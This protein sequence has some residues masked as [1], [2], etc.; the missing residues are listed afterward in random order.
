MYDASIYFG[1]KAPGQLLEERGLESKGYVLATIHRAENT[2][3]PENLRCLFNALNA[4]ANQMPVVLPLHPRTRTALKREN[5]LDSMSRGLHLLDPVGYLDMVT[6]EKNASLIATDSGGVQKEAFFHRVPCVTLRHETEWNELV[7]L[8]WNVLVPPTSAKAV[9]A[10]VLESLTPR[11][12]QAIPENLYGGGKA[13][14]QI[15]KALR[16]A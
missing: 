7:E 2:D 15:T 13:G 5:L 12:R 1:D 6:L 9:E 14:A 16:A 3:V 4:V 11:K 8:G 10:A